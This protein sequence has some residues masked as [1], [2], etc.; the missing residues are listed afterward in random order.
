MFYALCSP[1]RLLSC[2]FF[3]S[4]TIWDK[5]QN[6]SLNDG[7]FYQPLPLTAYAERVLTKRMKKNIFFCESKTEKKASAGNSTCP[8]LLYDWVQVVGAIQSG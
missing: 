1:W 5:Q 8:F 7:F 3:F 2:F 6:S 4:K